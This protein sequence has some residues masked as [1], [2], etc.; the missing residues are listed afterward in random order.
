MS[1]ADLLQLLPLMITAGTAVLVM[2]AIA[3]RRSHAAAL[4]ITVLGFLAALL[5]LPYL[6]AAPHPIMTTMIADRFTRFYTGLL[7]LTGIAVALLSYTYL[8]RRARVKEEYYLLLAL[9]TAG[10]IVLAS[11]VHFVTFFLG[12]E[13]LSV[14]LFALVAYLREFPLCIE[15]GLKY[16]VLAGVSTAFLL[17]GM[18]LV[19][20]ETGSMQFADIALHLPVAGLYFFTGMGLLLVGIGFKLAL[21]PFHLWT[22]DVY[23]GAPAPVTAFIA[24]ASKGAIIALLL[25]LIGM[26]DVRGIA[27][28]PLIFTVLAIASMFIGNLLGLLQNNV[29]RLLAY[30]SIANMGYLLVPF[31]ARGTLAASSV[32][33]YLVTYVVTSLGAFAV[34]TILSGPERDADEIEDYQ[35]LAWRRPWLAAAFTAMLLSLAGIPITAG[36]MGKFIAVA[37][38]VSTG[39]WLLV[40][41]LV[42]NS[43]IGLFYY[44]RVIVAMYR[45]EPAEPRP[46]TTVLAATVLL[47][48][49]ILLL[50]YG[51][52]PGALLAMIERAAMGLYG[53]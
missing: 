29:K 52:F 45:T 26:V 8:E 12:L 30:S 31:L 46:R 38:G 39:L 53:R 40:I 16:L 9:A 24:T 23:E 44:L 47:A 11:S 7:L 27:P 43:A 37:A 15:S 17:F 3:V 13:L 42:I 1:T 20:T 48:A 33:F 18:A 50:A 22:P 10:G 28:F 49:V 5:V 34:V 25:R 41:S 4:A 14:S 2:L 35:G 19:Y 6:D 32:T 21:V 51:L 36:F